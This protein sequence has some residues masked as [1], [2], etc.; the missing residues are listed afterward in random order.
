MTLEGANV[1]PDETLDLSGV[2]CPRKTERALVKL[3]IMEPWSVLEIII[4]AGEPVEKIAQS[5]VEEGH[6]L[7]AKTRRSD[8]WELVVRRTRDG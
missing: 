5:L 4:D 7:I 1:K 6:E 2:P 8:K 3:E